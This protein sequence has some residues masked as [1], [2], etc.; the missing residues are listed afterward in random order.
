MDLKN[1]AIYGF[2]SGIGLAILFVNTEVTTELGDAMTQTVTVPVFEYIVTV[3]RYGVVGAVV[4]LLYSKFFG[5][6]VAEEKKEKGKTYYLEMF[7]GVFVL[8][9]VLGLMMSW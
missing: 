5:K 1:S 7:V 9:I 2:L 8:C 3:L 6:E 4:G